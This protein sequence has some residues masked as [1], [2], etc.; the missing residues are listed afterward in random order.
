MSDQDTMDI[1]ADVGRYLPFLR[2]YARALTG[3]QTSGDAY[4]VAT[5][6]SIVADPAL[7]A[8]GQSPKVAL[9]AVF[10]PIRASSGALVV[11]A[12]GRLQGAAQAHLAGRTPNARAALLLHGIEGFSDGEV[13]A[14]MGISAADAAALIDTALRERE[15]SVAGVVL[16][17]EEMRSSAWTSRRLS[18]GWATGSLAWP[19]PARAQWKWPG[20]NGLT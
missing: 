12:E 15:A 13:A 3:N 11:E 9:F 2:R 17:R 10:H 1:S 7:M 8:R 6:E 14:I 4:A 18:R 16:V 20:R 19:T 5:L